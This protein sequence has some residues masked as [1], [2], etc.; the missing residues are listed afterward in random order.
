LDYEIVTV[1]PVADRTLW[2]FPDR[3]TM[4]NKFGPIYAIDD[5]FPSE[6]FEG[7]G[8]DRKDQVDLDRVAGSG[9]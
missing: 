8:Y 4:S 2:Q 1:E 3:R 9:S 7:R 5:P 6:R